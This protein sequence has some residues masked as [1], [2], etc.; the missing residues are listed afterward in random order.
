MFF[1]TVNKI[2]VVK[3]NKARTQNQQIVRDPNSL[4]PTNLII[5]EAVVHTSKIH[6]F[7]SAVSGGPKAAP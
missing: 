2:L 7:D 1:E 4:F 5:T 3:K 6:F